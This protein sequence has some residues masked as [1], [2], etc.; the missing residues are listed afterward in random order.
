MLGA[1]RPEE[2]DS[3]GLQRSSVGLE[4]AG[5]DWGGVR[6]KLQLGSE[7]K[8]VLGQDQVRPLSFRKLCKRSLPTWTLPVTPTSA[9]AKHPPAWETCPLLLS[10]PPASQ[11]GL[12]SPNSHEFYP[13]RRACLPLEE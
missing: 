6:G 12:A 1:Y 8:L 2:M 3:L 10:L 13:L 4:S 7:E 5:P 9:P 11:S